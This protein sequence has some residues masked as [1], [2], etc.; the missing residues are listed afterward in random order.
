MPRCCSI[1]LRR[2]PKTVQRNLQ[3][4][5]MDQEGIDPKI[6][7]DALRGLARLNRLTGVAASMYR[8]IRA[9]ANRTRNKTVTLIDVAS[10]SGDLPIAWAKWAKR[11]SIDLHVT[12]VDVSDLARRVQRQRADK[13]GIDLTI[14]GRDCVANGIPSGFDICTNSLFFHHLAEDDAIRLARSMT[15]AAEH[16]VVCDL[17]RSWGNRLLVMW[18]AHL[19]TRSP[20]V[21]VDARRSV[22]GSF[23][24]P[25]FESL[26]SRAC[27]RSIPVK[28]VLP[29]R[30]MATIHREQP[31]AAES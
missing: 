5:W 3:A 7:Q 14:L 13:E 28:R 1:A 19:A 17:E 11:E 4:E 12:T 27:D 15:K 31:S 25:E 9:I 21:H 6:H 8:Q 10:G 24:K 23:S 2:L 18:G 20:M 29:C 26:L 30:M 16:V 22:E